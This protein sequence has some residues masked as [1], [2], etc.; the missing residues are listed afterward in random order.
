VRNQSG[1]FGF[2]ISLILA[3]HGV[4][5]ETL[6]VDGN[7]TTD[8]LTIQSAID[9]AV[10]GDTVLVKP[11]VYVIAE[12]IDFNRQHDPDDPSS[13]PIKDVVVMSEDGPEATV[14]R[15]SDNPA[16]SKRLSLF[17]FE[18]GET[19]ASMLEGFTLTGGKGTEW[20]AWALQRVGGGVLCTNFSAPTFRSC[21]FHG[22]SANLGAGILC[23]T[24]SPIMD[25]CTFSNNE[26]VLEAVV[27]IRNSTV[28][29]TNCT[30]IANQG[31]GIDCS[32]GSSPVLTGCVIS[33]NTGN[34]LS[35]KG[36]SATMMVNCTVAGNASD[37]VR[38]EE[39]SIPTLVNCIVWDN[40][41]ES[42]RVLGNLQPA[43]SYSCIE[44]RAAWPGI[45]NTNEDPLFC[46]WEGPP[47]VF[48]DALAGPPG[49][50][51]IEKPY[52]HLP[53]ALDRFLL[54]INSRSPCR[55]H[56]KDGTNMGADLGICEAPPRPSRLVHLGLG[57]YEV[58]GLGLAYHVTLRGASREST[59]LQ[60]GLVGL[61]TGSSL[62]GATIVGGYPASILIGW[63]ESPEI[64]DCKILDGLSCAPG[65]FPRISGCVLTGPRECLV[66]EAES[67]PILE[68]C[69]IS[70]GS[71]GARIDRE[72][73]PSFSLCLIAG[74]TDGG[75][76]CNG[77]SAPT[78]DRC[79]IAGNA[80]GGIIG[81]AFSAPILKSCLLWNNPGGSLIGK[82]NS[83]I[84]ATYSCI[85]GSPIWPGYGNLNEDPLFCGWSRD[86]IHVDPS[87]SGPGDGTPGNPYSDLAS[88]L[89]FDLGLSKDSPCRGRGEGGADMGA[90]SQSCDRPGAPVLLALL[91]SGQHEA[92]NLNLAQKVSLRGVS[93]EGTTIR[94]SVFGLRSGTSLSRLAIVEGGETGGVIVNAGETPDIR[95]CL[96]GRHRNGA[97][98][99]QEGSGVRLMGCTITDNWSNWRPSAFSGEGCI[100]TLVNCVVTKNIAESSGA[101][102]KGSKKSKIKMTNCTVTGNTD[103][104]PGGGGGESRPLLMLSDSHLT[105]TNCILWNNRANSIEVSDEGQIEIDFCDIEGVQA[106]PGT[107]NFGEDPQFLDPGSWI[108]EEWTPGDLRLATTSPCRDRG[109][110]E[111]APTT[112]VEGGGRPCE[113][114]VDVGA[115]EMGDCPPP[116][117][118]LRGEIDGTGKIDIS[119]PIFLLGWLFL[120]DGLVSC[121]DAADANDDGIAD[122]SDAIHILTF[123]FIGGSPP[124]PPYP[125]C[126]RDEWIDGL[127]CV[128]SDLCAR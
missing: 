16:D 78:F 23:D 53:E 38:C 37:G 64:S 60:D 49:D 17:I 41:D 74:A 14:I 66:C 85:E 79:T 83:V 19:D 70:G 28:E 15:M 88:A 13:P 114:G 58:G 11:G 20:D 72:A 46:G 108:S 87:N 1:F 32:E 62:S 100:A 45:G 61:R 30:V 95:G 126:G 77:D 106:W 116:S 7:G 43:V 117:R 122:L 115:Y 128:S 51:T 27:Q 84:D 121:G 59:F 118:F 86:E 40:A 98:V 81:E 120:G 124:S 50:G 101:T 35:C 68:R 3:A 93:P 65:S 104:L 48:V 57:T 29:F 94:G 99:C 123:L 55:F 12:P 54:S 10:G 96:L 97:V 103:R 39:E 125:E 119:D 76:R 24:A 56:G 21:Q 22:N 107:G 18:N 5:A 73:Q 42:L 105:L 2:A 8:Y 82:R 89:D 127:G 91:A 33:G 25:S 34:G 109:T 67:A 26:A 6:V 90:Q 102:I 31:D 9:E 71:C 92:G 4:H 63:G 47:E 113:N 112:D 52:R 36:G 75:V 69:R 80:G 110:T 44:G 111:N